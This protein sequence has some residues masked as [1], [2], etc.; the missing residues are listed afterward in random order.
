MS[1]WELKEYVEEFDN[2]LMRNMLFWHWDKMSSF[3]E[4][5]LKSLFV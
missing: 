1:N 5:I 2:I 4:N 3:A